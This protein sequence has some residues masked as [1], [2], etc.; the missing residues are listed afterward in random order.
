MVM[1]IL[2]CLVILVSAVFGARK[3]FALTL[4]SFLQWFVC[5]ILAVIFNGKV[6]ELAYTYTQ[7][8][9]HISKYFMDSMSD[10]VQN[11]GAYQAVPDLFGDW[12]QYGSTEAISAAA[13][14]ITSVIMTVLSFLAIVFLIKL[15]SLMFTRLLSKKYHHGFI[16]F[17][18]GV[19]GFI[20]GIARGAVYVLIGLA[21][22]IPVLSFIWPDVA[23]PIFE[24]L[25]NSRISGQ[26]YDNNILLVAVRDL[27]S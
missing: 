1:D 13:E 17:L 16:A 19:G 15:I 22:L 7:M 26:L 6:K 10:S 11:S 5:L 14:Q 25:D 4:V 23:A 18:D 12:V 20:F 2:V 21:V 9:E 24:S 27:F 3:G 8:D